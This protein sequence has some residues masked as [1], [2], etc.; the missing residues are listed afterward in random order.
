MP[1]RALLFLFVCVCMCVCVCFAHLVGNVGYLELTLVDATSCSRLNGSSP[2]SMSRVLGPD[3]TQGILWMDA[4]SILHHRSETQPNDSIPLQIPMN[5][6][7]NHGF[8][9]GVHPQYLG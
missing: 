8:E 3:L 1:L 4:K 6:G 9:S 7:F 5:N 2:K